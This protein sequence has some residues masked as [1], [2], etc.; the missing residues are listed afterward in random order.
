MIVFRKR[1]IYWLLK[2]YFKKWRKG[3]LFFFLIGLL[4]FFLLRSTLTFFV[5]KIPIGYKESIGMVGAYTLDSLPQSI[6]QELSRGLTKVSVDGIPSPDLAK[7]WKIEDKGKKY[8]FILRK[9]LSFDDG[10]PLLSKHLSYN[11][12]NT[13]IEKP[14]PYTIIFKLKENYSPF[15]ITASR[16]VFKNGFVGIGNYKLKDITFNG[17]F[18]ASLTLVSVKNSYQTKIYHFYPSIEALKTAFILGEVSTLYG[19]QNH[20]YKNKSFSE[21]P[22]VTVEK[23]LNQKQLV[24]LFYNTQDPILSDDKLRNALS[25]AVPDTF[26]NGQ[27]NYSPFSPMSWV[28]TDIYNKVQD[29]D[30]SELLMSSSPVA[31]KSSSLKVEIKTFPRYKDTASLIAKEWKKINVNAK[32]EE[33]DAIPSQFQIFLG[34]FS[35]PKDPDQYTLWHQNQE[36]NITHYK[37]L[38]IDKLLE[39]G[40]KTVDLEER[41]KIYQD[42]QK[43]ILNDSPATFLYFPYEYDVK[44]K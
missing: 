43:Y 30:H 16:P 38:R 25:Y 14:D 6:L 24:T 41:K 28:Y 5:T 34:D 20:T 37:N 32:I 21:F 18:I 27:R 9:D 42:F 40:R 10:T 2:E 23:K 12:S 26:P 13:T 1:L 33:V 7:S 39:D 15:L 29:L 3:I 11:F 31:S 35:I 19:L 36:N 8:I 4:A 22:N 17:N 44:R